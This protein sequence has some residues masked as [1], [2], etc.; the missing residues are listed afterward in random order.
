MAACGVAVTLFNVFIN[1]LL[2]SRTE[3]D[4]CHFAEDDALHVCRP[5]IH[6]LKIDLEV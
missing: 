6:Q 4:I 3:S 1:D 2:L 5:T